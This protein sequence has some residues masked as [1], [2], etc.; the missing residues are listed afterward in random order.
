MLRQFLLKHSTFCNKTIYTFE[1]GAIYVKSDFDHFLRSH[2]LAV[3]YFRC[4]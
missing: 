4:A 3:D 1:V 2:L